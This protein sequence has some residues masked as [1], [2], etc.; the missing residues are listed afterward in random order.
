MQ[1]NSSFHNHFFLLFTQKMTLT[2][3]PAIA[4]S[5]RPSI[6]VSFLVTPLTS[7]QSAVGC[8]QVGKDLFTK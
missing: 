7:I 1:S 3:N 6:P 8:P 4:P 2:S 5:F